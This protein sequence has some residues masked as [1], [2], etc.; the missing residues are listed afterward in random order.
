MS[1]WLIIFGV[2]LT[3]S[4]AALA[5]AAE[6]RPWPSARGHR[7]RAREIPFLPPDR[8]LANHQRRP[9]ARPVAVERLNQ[10]GDSR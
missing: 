5:P 1:R 9:L 7:Y 8:Q 4:R 2:V 10:D 3:C 6:D